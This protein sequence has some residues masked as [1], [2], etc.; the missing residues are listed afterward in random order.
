MENKKT[1]EGNYEQLESNVKSILGRSQGM[2][3]SVKAIVKRM[4]E[5]LKEDYKSK[6]VYGSEI[7]NYIDGKFMELNAELENGV[8]NE[9]KEQQMERVQH[10]LDDVRV[11][12]EEMADIDQDDREKRKIED[13]LNNRHDNV[14]VTLL[15]IEQ[16]GGAFQN[17]VAY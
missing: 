6:G 1:Q 4:F 3:D 10:F 17:Q 14:V 5:Q 8:G 2:P 16:V 9:R 11:E 7:K 15:T 12:V 13:T